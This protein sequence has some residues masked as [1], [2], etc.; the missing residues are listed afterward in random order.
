MLQIIFK[1]LKCYEN[2][3]KVR[4]KW[5]IFSSKITNICL[6]F[7]CTYSLAPI[8]SWRKW[9]MWFIGDGAQFE[10][11][12]NVVF[13]LDKR[14]S[15]KYFI[16]SSDLLPSLLFCNWSCV[17]I[18]HY[19]EFIKLPTITVVRE[20]VLKMTSSDELIPEVVLLLYSFLCRKNFE[21]K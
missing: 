1:E 17:L 12:V 15:R 8:R 13:P 5:D 20:S 10:Y 7:E 18:R 19:F 9:I 2:T 3:L 14:F 11:S 4:K 16:E 6:D 21:P